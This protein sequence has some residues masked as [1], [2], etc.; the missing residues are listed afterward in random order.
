M[1]W[2]GGER[3]MD[4]PR[5]TFYHLLKGVWKGDRLCFFE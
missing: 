5:S 2:I 4:G 3:K 1:N